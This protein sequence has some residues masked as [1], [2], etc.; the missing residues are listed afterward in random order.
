M[1]VLLTAHGYPPR[2]IG[3]TQLHTQDLAL[4]LAARGHAVDVLCPGR[5]EPGEGQGWAVETVHGVAVHRL[6]LPPSPPD[7]DP[8][9]FRRTWHD[10]RAEAAFRELAA[11]L[12]PDIVHFHHF[13]DLSASLATA[14][15]EMGLPALLTLHDLWVLCEQPHFLRPNLDFCREGPADPQA[16]AACLAGRRPHWRLCASP[17]V[18]TACFRQRL[19]AMRRAVEAL[20][21]VVCLARFQADRLAAHG[22]NPRRIW[23]VPL[24]L[25]L[26]AARP[27][28]PPPQAGRDL[29]L[30][31]LGIVTPTKGTD[32]AVQAMALAG[33][34]GMTL[35]VHGLVCDQGYLERLRAQHPPERV[36]WRGTYLP[37]DLPAILSGVDALVMPSRSENTPLV[38][39]ESLGLG[40]PVVGPDVGGVPE[41]LGFG[42]WGLVFRSGDAASLA[43]QLERLRDEPGLL[44]SLRAAIPPQRSLDDEVDALE[45]VYRD[46]L[47]DHGR[48]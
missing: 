19:E 32:L 21:G 6:L 45:A 9:D 16:C 1:R 46:C 18:L 10:P 17:E 4:A 44:H 31:C 40:V 38:V 12:A 37:G 20:T 7:P 15:R 33:W 11:R 22:L 14:A 42:R 35:D 25:P 3:G 34:R 48:A 39:L 24:G 2:Q 43:R 5:P 29:R 8:E 26:P 47:A 30:A 27:A 41:M 28:P 23:H 13:F 36:N